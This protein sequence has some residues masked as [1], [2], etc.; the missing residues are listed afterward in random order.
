MSECSICTCLSAMELKA[1]EDGDTVKLAQARE[2][3]ARH[4]REHQ[5]AELARAIEQ[6]QVN[7]AEPSQR[8]W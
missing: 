7:L 5:Q 3:I 2:W 8:R 6:A 4:E 1:I